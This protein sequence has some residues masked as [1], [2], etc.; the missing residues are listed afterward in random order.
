MCSPP[1]S[2]GEILLLQV[3]PAGSSSWDLGPPS[4]FTNLICKVGL[5][6]GNWVS[7][8]G[9]LESQPFRKERVGGRLGGPSWL[10]GVRLRL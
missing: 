10:L 5:K 6:L 7:G 8:L 4:G 3:T 9:A 1:E 2:W